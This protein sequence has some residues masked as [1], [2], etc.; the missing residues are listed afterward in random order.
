[1]ERTGSR[2]KEKVEGGEARGRV[3]IK[4]KELSEG[5]VGKGGGVRGEM[6]GG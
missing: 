4:R 1:M 3:R 2:S 5:G 6:R